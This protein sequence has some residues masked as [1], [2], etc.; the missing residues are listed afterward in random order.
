MRFLFLV[1]TIFVLAGCGQDEFPTP[2]PTRT[3]VPTFTP[4]ALPP[5]NTPT[6][7]YLPQSPSPASV[8]TVQPEVSEQVTPPSIAYV[9]KT[10]IDRGGVQVTLRGVSLMDWR[11]AQSY[12]PFMQGWAETNQLDRAQVFG[13][14]TV[15]VTNTT[16]S[17]IIIFPD[18]GIVVIGPEQVDLSRSLFFSENVGMEFFP[19]V[20]KKGNIYFWLFDQAWQDIADGASFVYEIRSPS[21]ENF[22]QLADEPYLFQAQ[23]SPM[24]WPLPAR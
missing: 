6:K 1:L 12:Y 22:I 15:A 13:L 14:M 3:A 11:Q 19:G 9:E 23:L 10:T 17:K 24:P 18:Q 7:E 20:T 5:T 8:A 21:G 16:A 4:T 2:T